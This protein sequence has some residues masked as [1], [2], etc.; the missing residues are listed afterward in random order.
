MPPGPT[1]LVV[2]G[3]RRGAV[4]EALLELGFV[5]EPATDTDVTVLDTFDGRLHR[6]GIR[7][8][9]HD[10]V[11]LELV[12]PGLA[13]VRVDAEGSPASATEIADPSFRA[14]VEALIG[15]RL[16]MARLRYTASTA[17][18][19]ARDEDGRATA[20][21]VLSSHIAVIP[22]VDAP[23]PESVVEVRAVSDSA[24]PARR[25]VKTLVRLGF[26]AID[27]DAAALVAGGLGVGLGDS[28]RPADVRLDP[29]APAAFGVRDV[30]ANLADSIEANWQGTIDDGDPDFLHDLRVAVRRTRSIITE[31]KSVLPAEVVTKVGKQ[32]TWLGAVTGVARDLDVH[33]V[34]WDDDARPLGADAAAA[35]EPV[36]ALLARRRA[37]AHTA[38]AEALTSPS[39]TKLIAKWPTIIAGIPTHARPGPDADEPLGGIVRQRIIEAQ[40]ILIDKGRLITPETPAD[41]VHDLRKDA[42]RLRYLLECFATILAER[43]R[44]K[45]VK[46]LKAL[47]DNLGTHQDAEVHVALLREVAVEMGPDVIPGKT[48]DALELMIERLEAVRLAARTKFAERFAAYDTEA[49]VLAFEDMLAALV[50]D[51]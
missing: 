40:A 45:F 23:L 12:R 13:T 33:L 28:A 3:H 7:L 44:K 10:D 6:A 48:A 35:L 14:A 37:E 31:T 5:F 26:E 41:E 11:A 18:A 16:L 47:Q 15:G 43:P 38:L 2:D 36:R 4:V 25:A 39:A 51:G 1:A 42:K 32:F 29:E 22:T 24:K 49:T 8:A 19:V 27:G 50:P 46:R 20:E 9:L 30:L 34:D 17:L 21:I